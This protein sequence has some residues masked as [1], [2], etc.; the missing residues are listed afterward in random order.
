[1]LLFVDGWLWLVMS[2]KGKWIQHYT[3]SFHIFTHSCK[4]LVIIVYNSL[5]SLSHMICVGVYLHLG[6]LGGNMLVHNS[7]Y[8]SIWALC[9]T[10]PPS[11][12]YRCPLFYTT[13]IYHYYHHYIPL[14]IDPCTTLPPSTC[15]LCQEGLLFLPGRSHVVNSIFGFLIGEFKHVLALKMNGWL[16]LIN[17][18]FAYSH[19]A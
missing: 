6:N 14:S 16:M 1:M 5:V 11:I 4:S 3:T 15:P 13:M 10:L 8:I 18:T 17:V 12:S 2:L 7:P 9:T 19:V